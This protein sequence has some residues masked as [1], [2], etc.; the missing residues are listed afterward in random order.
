[1]KNALECGRERAGVRDAGSKK[2]RFPGAKSRRRCENLASCSQAVS[3]SCLMFDQ[4]RERES[5]YRWK[6]CPS[7]ILCVYRTKVSVDPARVFELVKRLSVIR[8]A[9]VEITEKQR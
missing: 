7:R 8:V 9:R 2:M 6:L 4:F 3:D 1:V 5:I